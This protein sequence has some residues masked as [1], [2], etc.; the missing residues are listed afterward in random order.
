[1]PKS[2]AAILLTLA[3]LSA[4]ALAADPKPNGTA[5]HVLVVLWD[6]MRP[7]FIAPQFCPNLYNLAQNGTFFRHH[8]SSYISTTE[9]NGAAISTGNTP[10]KN[11]I[12]ANADFRQEF[13]F[14]STY[15]TEG[16]DAIRRGDLLTGGHY[17]TSPTLA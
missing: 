6:G 8:H 17:F 12:Q 16:L 1:M 13:S 4:S 15:A 10:G 2:P 3:T 7:D 9:V 11:G 14:M 5:E